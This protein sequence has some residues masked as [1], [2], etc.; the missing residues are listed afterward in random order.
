[1]ARQI[2]VSN[3][4]YE[5]LLE[6]KGS[7]SFSQVIKESLRPQDEKVDIMSLAGILKDDKDSLERLKKQI[8]AEREANYGR[9]FQ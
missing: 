7:K 3:E 8:A 6:R 4:V 1:M 5:L 2:S 9:T